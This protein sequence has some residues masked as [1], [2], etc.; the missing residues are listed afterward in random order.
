MQTRR[1]KKK[2]PY[3]TIIQFALLIGLIPILYQLFII[4]EVIREWINAPQTIVYTN[5]GY[6]KCG[7]TNKNPKFCPIILKDKYVEE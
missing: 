2:I 1:K 5:I 4:E 7:G 6:Y 3:E